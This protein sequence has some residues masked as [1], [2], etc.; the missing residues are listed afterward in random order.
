MPFASAGRLVI[1]KLPFV[2]VA[3]GEYPSAVYQLILMPFSLI[4]HSSLIENICSLA[5]FFTILPEARIHVFVWVRVETLALF[6]TLMEL[7]YH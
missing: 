1:L 2:V 5:V 7:A 6:L 4:S 3:I